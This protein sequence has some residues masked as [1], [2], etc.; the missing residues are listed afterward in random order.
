MPKDKEKSRAASRRYYARKHAERFGPEAGDQRGRYGNHAKAEAS[1]KWNNRIISS[2]GYVKVRVGITHPLAD[3]NG[4]AYEHLLVWIS[5]G[6]P[7]P[8]DEQI[9]HHKNEFKTDSRLDNLELLTRPDHNRLH[10]L[11]MER[12]PVTGRIVGKKHHPLTPDE[13]PVL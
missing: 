7:A 8:T 2:E 13:M 9:L 11:D 4:Y 10:M 12:D 3:P 1:G 6:R 5:A